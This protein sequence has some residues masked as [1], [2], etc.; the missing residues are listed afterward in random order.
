MTIPPALHLLFRRAIV[1]SGAAR[2]AL[3]WIEEMQGFR[4]VSVR[5]IDTRSRGLVAIVRGELSLPKACFPIEAWSSTEHDPG[6]VVDI[7][8]FS[9]DHQE[10]LGNLL[11]AEVACRHNPLR[12]KNILS[13][14]SPRS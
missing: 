1:D 3:D 5:L 11:D 8:T 9:D 13:P 4:P 2:V 10:H 12:L 6:P 7:G 14:R